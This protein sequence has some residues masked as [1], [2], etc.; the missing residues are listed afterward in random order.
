M[1]TNTAVVK[2]EEP[3]IKTFKP[4]VKGKLLVDLLVEKRMKDACANLEYCKAEYVAKQANIEKKLK[5]FFK[6]FLKNKDNIAL[7][8]VTWSRWRHTEAKYYIGIYLE[9][10]CPELANEIKEFAELAEPSTPDRKQLR[11]QV[12]RELNDLRLKKIME[13]PGAMEAIEKIN[14]AIQKN[15]AINI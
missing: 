6:K 3:Q 11:A 7:G 12:E 8:E 1:N 13:Q 4:P 14:N 15:G 2:V 9:K 10:E 5:E